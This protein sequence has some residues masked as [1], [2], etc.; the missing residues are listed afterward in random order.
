[1]NKNLIF[2]LVAAACVISAVILTQ[3]A[4]HKDEFTA[5]KNKFSVNWSTQEDAYRRLVFFANL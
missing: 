2:T 3:E 1:M 5:W 4:E